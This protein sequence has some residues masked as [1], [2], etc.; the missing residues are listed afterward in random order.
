[1]RRPGAN[2]RSTAG[3]EA[4]EA[5]EAD[6]GE[7]VGGLHTDASGL[8]RQ[9]SLGTAHIRTVFQQLG[10]VADRQRLGDGRQPGRRQTHRHGIRA[11]AQQGRDAIALTRLLGL[12]LRYGCLNGSQTCIG[13]HHVDLV[14]DTFIA[15]LHGDV[16]R[17][18]LVFQVVAGNVFAQL[19]TAQLPVGIHQFG[20][21]GH[22]KLIQIGLGHLLIGFAGFQF[23]LNATEQV[24]LPGHV[25]PQVVA[26]LV[27]PVVGF[28][29]HLCTAYFAAGA[30][31]DHW[32]GIVADVVA[33]GGSSFQA[34]ESHA[35]FAVA[36]QRLGH[37]LIQ[38]RVIEL[39]PP[40]GLRATAIVS[41][42]SGGLDIGR[43]GVRR[44][45]V[46]ADG[47]GRQRQHQQA[48]QEEFCSLHQ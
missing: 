37:Q 16:A 34:G 41:T 3:G 8:R 48:R 24:D 29:R 12:Q 30:A 44:L 11:F 5:A 40:D 23:A 18:L 6:P 2:L 10:R 26:F 46:G 22:L 42:L 32:H 13:A 28:T 43:R 36:L 14:A 17:V 19:R 1:M 4:Q 27:D 35:Q 47:A 21:H 25:Q 15:Q 20:D 38:G 9:L 45:V 31:G 33:N 39:L 7:Q